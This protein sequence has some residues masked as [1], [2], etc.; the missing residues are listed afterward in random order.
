MGW[1][2]GGFLFFWSV[3][4]CILPI[5]AFDLPIL[6]NTSKGIEIARKWKRPNGKTQTCCNIN[7]IWPHNG[8]LTQITLETSLLAGYVLNQS[9]ASNCHR[10]NASNACITAL[11]IEPLH[12]TRTNVKA[13]NSYIAKLRE[14]AI[15]KI[16]GLS[17]HNSRSDQPVNF[18][19]TIS[20]I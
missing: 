11:Q 9:F 6:K 15:G 16:G 1:K 10:Y 14:N 13:A 17:K 4:L 5:L 8:Y 20:F 3:Y 2:Q 12:T 19:F 7:H 18:I